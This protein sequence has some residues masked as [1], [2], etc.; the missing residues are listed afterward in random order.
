MKYKHR[1]KPLQGHYLNP[2]WQA[3]ILS[4]LAFFP[5]NLST[6]AATV[7]RF[8]LEELAQ[9]S[10]KIV[11]GQCISVESRW[12]SKGT[13]IL[14]YSRFSVSENLKGPGRSEVIVVTPGGTV[15]TKTQRVAGMPLYQAGQEAMLFLEPARNGGWQTLGMGQGK[16]SIRQNPRTGVREA[17]HSL[18]GLEFYSASGQETAADRNGSSF[19]LEQLIQRVREALPGQ[20]SE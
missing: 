13:L 4:L 19:P 1:L 3:S 12:N 16:F 17:I 10:T 5:W 9:K 14:T 15:G 20:R 11:I 8:S 18:Q 6:R 7:E 2:V